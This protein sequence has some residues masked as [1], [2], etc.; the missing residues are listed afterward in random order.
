MSG[1][2]EKRIRRWE[3]YESIHGLI[4]PTK[5]FEIMQK[6]ME[7]YHRYGELPV[8]AR[9]GDSLEAVAFTYPGHPDVVLLD[10][11]LPLTWME[12]RC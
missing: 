7:L 10:L 1:T 3:E 11:V 8:P 12:W 9:L 2:V 4:Y 6:L 5:P